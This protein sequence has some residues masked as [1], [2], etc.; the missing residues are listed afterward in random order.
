MR[1][2]APVFYLEWGSSCC[3][4]RYCE[5]TVDDAGGAKLF[6]GWFVGLAA[7]R[8]QQRCGPRRGDN[9]TGTTTLRFLQYGEKEVVDKS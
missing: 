3:V 8:Q 1:L 4:C 6:A 5:M 2:G 7:C 9:A